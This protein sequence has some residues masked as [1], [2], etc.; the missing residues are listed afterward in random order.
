MFADLL[1]P[2]DE[3][4]LQRLYSRLR[5][6]ASG[7]NSVRGITGIAIVET[8]GGVL[9]P[10]PSGTPQADLFRPMRLPV[11]LV[12]DHKL[13]GIGSTI[14][15][16]ESLIMRGY[17]IDAVVCFDDRSK[18]DNAAYL[19]NY[20]GKMGISAFTLPWIPDLEGVSKKEEADRMAAYYQVNSRSPHLYQVAGQVID[21]HIKRSGSIGNMASR[22][23]DVIWHPFTQHKHVEKADDILVFDSAYGDYFQV[24]H[25]NLSLQDVEHKKDAPLLYPA[26]DGAASWWTQ[27]RLCPH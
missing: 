21:M 5:E 1:E 24:K 26:F 15:A 20:F 12:G 9:S 17:D 10:G 2:S 14:S 25:T 19:T 8:A 7:T 23:E 4:L 22:T 3:H 11:V 13:G 6:A 27:V 16:A 18:Y